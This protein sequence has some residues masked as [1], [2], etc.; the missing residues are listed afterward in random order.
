MKKITI[1]SGGQTGADRSALQFAIRNNILH[2]GWC[3]KGRR[4]EDGRIAEIFS[5]DETP[6]ADYKQRTEWNVR[7][8]DATVIFTLEKTLCGGTLLTEELARCMNKPCAII[9]KENCTHECNDFLK[10][11]MDQHNVKVLN[12]AGPRE[13]EQPGI[14]LFVENYLTNALKTYCE[15]KD[16]VAH[17]L[18]VV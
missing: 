10:E 6:S 8:S 1:R 15:E 14:G 18:Y 5:L 17:G 4:A 12:I 9:V 16:S 3:P 7:D 2:G 11:F 13:S